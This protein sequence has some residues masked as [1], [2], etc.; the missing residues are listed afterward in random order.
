MLNCRNKFN[1]EITF[2]FETHTK[3]II[4]HNHEKRH[5]NER[6]HNVVINKFRHKKM[7]HSIIL[8]EIDVNTK[9]LFYD[10][11]LTFDLIIDLKMKNRKN[12]S[13]YFQ[14]IT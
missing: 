1:F 12:I 3:K 11:V 7:L 14:R 8:F 9:I 5:I 2:I 4:L 13:F 6:I 10:I